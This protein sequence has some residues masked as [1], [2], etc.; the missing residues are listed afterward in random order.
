MSV[1]QYAGHVLINACVACS[2]IYER[3]SSIVNAGCLE[4]SDPSKQGSA[5]QR[6]VLDIVG[7]LLAS[8]LLKHQVPAWL[9][10]WGGAQP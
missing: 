4:G 6:H 9:L 10:W 7:D 1:E 8:S 3:P 2:V 5:C